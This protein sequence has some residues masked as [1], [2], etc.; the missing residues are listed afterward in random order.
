[1]ITLDKELNELVN[2]EKDRE[3]REYFCKCIDKDRTL[4][5]SF[6]NTVDKTLYLCSKEQEY[7]KQKMEE[8]CQDSKREH[9]EKYLTWKKKVL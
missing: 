1:M 4:C 9:E 7:C 5:E 2:K 8:Y 6:N 3:L